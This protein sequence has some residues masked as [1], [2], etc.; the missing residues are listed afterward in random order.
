MDA[1]KVGGKPS[2]SVTRAVFD[3]GTSLLAGPVADVKA[4]RLSAIPDDLVA[5]FT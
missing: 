4:S 1:L 2:T 5:C 3:T